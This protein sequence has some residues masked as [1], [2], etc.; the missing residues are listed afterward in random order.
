MLHLVE[1]DRGETPPCRGLPVN[2]FEAVARHILA[3][4]VELAALAHLAPQAQT[5]I[6]CLAEQRGRGAVAQV[7]I[8]V[9]GAIDRTLA[10]YLPET[11]RRER[12]HVDLRQLVVATR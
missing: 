5:D 6:G 8:D 10:A 3:Q 11:H 9:Q 1:L 7:R 2:I 4:V 12:L